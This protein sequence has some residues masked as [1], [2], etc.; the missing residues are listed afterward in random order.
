[1]TTNPQ[2]TLADA[3]GGNDT[4][5]QRPVPRRA[6]PLSDDPTNHRCGANA[7]QGIARAGRAESCGTLSRGAHAQRGPAVDLVFELSKEVTVDQ[8]NDT[9]APPPLKK[10]TV[11]EFWVW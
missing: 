8:V 7:M 9:P 11:R 10:A 1:M 4:G 3:T 2:A 5:P 6:A